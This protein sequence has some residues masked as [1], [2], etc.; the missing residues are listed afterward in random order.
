MEFWDTFW[1]TMWGALGGAVIGAFAA[2]LFSLDLR[3]REREDRKQEREQDRLDREAEREFAHAA[4]QAELDRTEKAEA[5][6][7]WLAICG[8]LSSYVAVP[9]WEKSKYQA[10]A[11]DRISDVYVLGQ[12]ADRMVANVLK[13]FGPND[14]AVVR[15]A[16]RVSGLLH[17]YARGEDTADECARQLGFIL[18]ESRKLQAKAKEQEEGEARQLAEEH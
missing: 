7:R 18:V 17:R 2:W 12:P 5:A 4:R 3:R 11:L 15:T 10:A 6:R 14:I 1:A 8:A 16:G 13:D 9:G